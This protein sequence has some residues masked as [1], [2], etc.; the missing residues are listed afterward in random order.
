[1]FTDMAIAITTE[2]PF[3]LSIAIDID[4]EFAGGRIC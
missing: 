2:M 4:G 3:V 1:M